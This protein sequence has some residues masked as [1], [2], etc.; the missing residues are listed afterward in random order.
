VQPLCFIS[1]NSLPISEPL[2]TIAIRSKQ[3]TRFEEAKSR[4]RLAKVDL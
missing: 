1:A 2:G 3:R 4:S